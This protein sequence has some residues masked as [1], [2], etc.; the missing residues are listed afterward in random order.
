[1]SFK[2]SD[3]KLLPV[4][5]TVD[6]NI[7][8]NEAVGI[9]GESGSGKSMF[10]R[11]LIGT[12]ARHSAV[13]TGGS[14]HFEDLDL[15]AATE[16]TW[17]RIRGQKIGYVPQSSLA[18]LNPVLT[19]ETQ[20]IESIRAVKDMSRAAAQRE[21]LDLLDQV[22]I[23]RPQQVLKQLPHQLS[24]GMRQRVMIA[25]AIA[26]KPK[27]LIAD[28]PTT[29]LDVTIQREIL[30]LISKLR[31]E[32]GMALILVSHDMAV[33]EEVC[34]K[35]LVMYAGAAVE[36]GTVE[37]TLAQP[38][39]PYTRALQASRLDVATPGDDLEVIPG[40]P[41]T[42]G[43]WPSGCRFRM[44]CALATEDCV[45]DPHPPLRQV[46]TQRTACIHWDRMEELA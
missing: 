46:E 39:H 20:L 11:A 37:E 32:L 9:V 44:R 17:R 3:G 6:L 5:D 22:H 38:R 7:H 42:V 41:V 12:A 2:K 45:P 1:M 15:A 19:I 21:A 10:C 24:G 14:I 16:K 43:A 23:A 25:T 29:A 31:Q 28:E 4:L 13:I 30:S 8:P 34:D 35:V 27:L 26:Q 18:G 40:E 36:F 33:I